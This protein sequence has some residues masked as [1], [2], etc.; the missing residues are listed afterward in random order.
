M[1][2]L[3]NEKAFESET[4]LQT[5]NSE[6]D[7]LKKALADRERQLVTS[8]SQGIMIVILNYYA[9][10]KFSWEF[11]FG[12]FAYAKFNKFKFPLLIDFHNDSQYKSFLKIKIF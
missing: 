2:A 10:R 11:N 7:R 1:E 9:G 3:L 5:A 8:P 6:I 12:Y 4:Q